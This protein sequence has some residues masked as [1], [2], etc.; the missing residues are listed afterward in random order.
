MQVLATVFIF[1]LQYEIVQKP[2]KLTMEVHY[3]GLNKTFSSFHYDIK[4]NWKTFGILQ[5]QLLIIIKSTTSKNDFMVWIFFINSNV[6]I[7][8]NA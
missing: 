4:L 8:F 7:L 5:V 2:S 3:L 1:A 6:V